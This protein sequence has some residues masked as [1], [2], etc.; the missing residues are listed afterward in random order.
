MAGLGVEGRGHAPEPREGPAS[1]ASMEASVQGGS[2]QI[3]GDRGRQTLS[4]DFKSTGHFTPL[5]HTS[6]G[7]EVP[8]CP[9]QLNCFHRTSDLPCLTHRSRCLRQ[10]IEG[11]RG[12]TGTVQ[13]GVPSNEERALCTWSAKWESAGRTPQEAAPGI[14]KSQ[15]LTNCRSP[16]P[17]ETPRPH[18][19]KQRPATSPVHPLPLPSCGTHPPST[20]SSDD[21]PMALPAASLLPG[22]KPH[23]GGPLEGP[24]SAMI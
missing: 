11:P 5:K 15:D 2:C 23:P 10:A 8:H 13:T 4:W 14:P 24:S 6:K 20:R 18:R 12:P 1:A 3:P 16:P 7:G 22:S 17:P 9:N 21:F 19:P